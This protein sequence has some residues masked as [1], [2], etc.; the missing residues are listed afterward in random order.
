MSDH[1]D[2]SPLIAPSPMAEPSEIDLEAGQGEQIQCRI[3]LE[4]DGDFSHFVSLGIS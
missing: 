1:E 2:V 4:T 3:C